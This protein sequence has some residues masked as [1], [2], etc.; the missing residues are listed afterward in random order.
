MA[1][2]R[3]NI[4]ELI[5]QD[6][7]KLSTYLRVPAGDLPYD[8]GVSVWNRRGRIRSM[9]GVLN[10][11]ASLSQV[12]G[13]SK[14]AKSNASS[15][16]EWIL[17]RTNIKAIILPKIITSYQLKQKA[18]QLIK[19]ICINDVKKTRY[20]LVKSKS[21]MV[22]EDGHY[23][24]IDDQDFVSLED[25]RYGRVRYLMDQGISAEGCRAGSCEQ[26]SRCRGGSGTA[27][28]GEIHGIMNDGSD[29]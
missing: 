26:I 17:A 15:L 14:A 7:M 24:P 23:I 29:G 3:P 20:E 27:H 10:K 21:M 2:K 22:C 12:V 19:E 11:H 13:A 28:G 9:Y 6:P 25:Y 8:E 18:T 5:L 4:V 16:F 1:W